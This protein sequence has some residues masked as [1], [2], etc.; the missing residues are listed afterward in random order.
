MGCARLFDKLV[1]H[2]TRDDG[3]RALMAQLHEPK[4]LQQIE[5]IRLD[6][7]AVLLDE[8]RVSREICHQLV[9]CCFQCR[10]DIRV[11]VVVVV[12]SCCHSTTLEKTTF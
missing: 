2:L 6:R 11:V 1:E 9:Y 8:T 12:G 4:I 5:Q 10:L 3:R 7:R